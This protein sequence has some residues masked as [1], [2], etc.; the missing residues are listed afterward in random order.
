[1]AFVCEPREDD[2]ESFQE[3]LV[4]N[5]HLKALL[6][7]QQQHSQAPPS[8]QQQQ[9]HSQV[10]GGSSSRCSSAP[11]SARSSVQTGEREAGKRLS[12]R[13]P[14]SETSR[15]AH[16]NELLLQR[17]SEQA[18]GGISRPGGGFSFQGRAFEGCSQRSQ[19]ES[20]HTVNRRRRADSIARSNNQFAER[21][22][23]VKSSGLGRPPTRPS[24]QSRATRPP[25][26]TAPRLEQR[27]WQS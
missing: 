18:L 1:M 4:L 7:Q 14:S 21:L 19:H 2:L 15:V 20:S 17:L 22:V 16:D 10:H 6:Q 24:S 5:R 23:N 25:T 11:N 27:E 3:A 13:G 8:G 26:Q 12:S 9:Q